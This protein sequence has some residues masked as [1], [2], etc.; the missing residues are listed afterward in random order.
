MHN[1]VLLYAETAVVTVLVC[2][3]VHYLAGLDW[4]WAIA[5]G[6]VASMAVRAAVRRNEIRDEEKRR[7]RS[8]CGVGNEASRPPRGRLPLPAPDRPRRRARGSGPPRRG[9]S[10]CRG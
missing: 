2:L 9:R 8:P 1:R 4:P 5:L 6:L 7:L 10:G 3:P